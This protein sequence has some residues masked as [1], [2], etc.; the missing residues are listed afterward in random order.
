MQTQVSQ[1]W[2]SGCSSAV[3]TA[4]DS[5]CAEVTAAPAVW[6]CWISAACSCSE[7]SAASRPLGATGQCTEERRITHTKPSE[8]KFF[9]TAW[10]MVSPI[11]TSSTVTQRSSCSVWV[12]MHSHPA[13]SPPLLFCPSPS[14]QLLPAL[15]PFLPLQ[16]PSGASSEHL[17]LH[18]LLPVPPLSLFSVL[19][20]DRQRDE[21]CC[22]KS[23]SV[24]APLQRREPQ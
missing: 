6:C 9:F 5:P 2:C 3:H 12:H 15:Q 20:F 21:L 1:L 4:T 16:V 17:L 7:P 11:P 8:E 24:A 14:T 23:V 10:H 22:L 13:L 19:A 18:V